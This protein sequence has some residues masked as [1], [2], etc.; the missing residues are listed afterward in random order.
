[1]KGKRATTT[2]IKHAGTVDFN[3][4]FWSAGTFYI[5]ALAVMFFRTTMRH[6]IKSLILLTGLFI[7]S[8]VGRQETKM[9]EKYSTVVYYNDDFEYRNPERQQIRTDKYLSR[10]TLYIFFETDFK[11]DTVDIKINKGSTRTLYLNTDHSIGVAD[12]VH[13]GDIKSINEIEIIKN[14]GTP[15]TINLIDKTMNLWTVN[16]YGDTLRAQR[17]KYL[18]TYE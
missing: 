11:S 18:P 9:G 16:F 13:Y 7:S 3:L 6:L 5:Q 1:M 17:T 12:M 14:N 10:D 15:L 2:Y 8:C 4:L